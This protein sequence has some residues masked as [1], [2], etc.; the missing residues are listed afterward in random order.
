MARGRGVLVAQVARSTLHNQ[1]CALFNQRH[2][3]DGRQ[4]CPPQ[5]SSHFA[6]GCDTL[7]HSNRLHDC[8]PSGKL[9]AGALVPFLS[10]IAKDSAPESGAG[11]EADSEE[12]GGDGGGAGGE[13]GSKKAERPPPPILALDLQKLD[14]LLDTDDV[15][16]IAAFE[17]AAAARCRL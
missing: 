4:P 10:K 11:Q 15:W 17:G 2:I 9:S 13:A 8:S 12:A 3:F 16:L 5:Y 14:E 1:R 7:G 6:S